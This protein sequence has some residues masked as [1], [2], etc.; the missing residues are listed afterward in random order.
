VIERQKNRAIEIHDSVLDALSLHNGDAV[1]HFSHLYIHETEGV[2]G[3]DA[4]TGWSQQGKLTIDEATVD[5]SISEL[6]RDLWDGHVAM[7]GRIS[8]NVIPIPL[9]YVGE[10]ELRLEAWGKV[11]EVISVR[12][13]GAK[14]ELIGEANYIEEFRHGK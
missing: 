14:L 9:S 3:V 13:T 6:P 7:G 1:L 10:V 11:R 4:G 12:G 5:G 8:D 2:P